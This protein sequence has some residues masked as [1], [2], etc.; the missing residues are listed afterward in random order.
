MRALFHSNE[1]GTALLS[2]IQSG[3]QFP[4]LLDMVMDRLDG[5]EFASALRK[6]GDKI[7]MIFIS[8]NRELELSTGKI[9]PVSKYRLGV[10]QRQMVDYLSI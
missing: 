4:I 8:N 1:S 6:Q 9:L 10:L 5:M 7:D 3:A 2:V